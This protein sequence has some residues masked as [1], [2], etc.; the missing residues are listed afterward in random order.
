MKKNN[1]AKNFEKIWTTRI[2]KGA[3]EMNNVHALL[4]AELHND[5]YYAF[6]GRTAASWARVWRAIEAARRTIKGDK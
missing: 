6:N 1:P 2:I 5:A 4:N 3:L